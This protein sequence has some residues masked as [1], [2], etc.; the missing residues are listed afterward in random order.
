[1]TSCH[2]DHI[3]EYLRIA[4]ETQNERSF[5]DKVS[6]SSARLISFSIVELLACV[7]C[8]PSFPV[9]LIMATCTSRPTKRSYPDYSN[10]PL[11]LSTIDSISSTIS[12]SQDYRDYHAQCQCSLRRK[13]HSCDWPLP[14]SKKIKVTSEKKATDQEKEQQYHCQVYLRLFP[15]TSKCSIDVIVKPVKSPIDESLELDSIVIAKSR[16][17]KTIRTGSV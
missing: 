10:D 3:S 1:M 5:N 16:L 11:I 13:R 17:P 9:M 4:R 8:L 12:C 2:H 14:H 6:L 15:S 7:Y